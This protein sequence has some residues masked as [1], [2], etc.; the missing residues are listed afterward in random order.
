MTNQSVKP[1]IWFWVVAVF[2]LL[3][4]LMG[5]KAYL[6]QAFMS[7]DAFA[8]LEAAM[9]DIFNQTPAWVTA[10]FAIAVWGGA[11]GSLLLILRKSLAHTVLIISLVGIVIQMFHNVFLSDN[12]DAYGP[13]GIPMALMILGFGVGLV[14]FSKKSKSAGW[15]R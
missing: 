3:W 12:L 10:A 15:I 14:F 5:V 9:Q 7:D 8:Q 4:N 11:L 1:P 2:A 6:D 13:G